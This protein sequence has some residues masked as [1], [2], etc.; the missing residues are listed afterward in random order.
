MASNGQ[1]AVQ[2]ALGAHRDLEIDQVGKAQISFNVPVGATS[3]TAHGPW[4]TGVSNNG[5]STGSRRSI[6]CLLA[7][8]SLC[9]LFAFSSPGRKETPSPPSVAITTHH[10]PSAGL[11]LTRVPILFRWPRSHTYPEVTLALQLLLQLTPQL[12]ACGLLYRGTAAQ[13]PAGAH[14]DT[15]LKASL[16]TSRPPDGI[17]CRVPACC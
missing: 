4:P 11:E 16:V 14:A 10:A 2:H 13:T 5:G 6:R 17:Q 1:D 3:R 15:R 9:R 8:G 7:A 12:R